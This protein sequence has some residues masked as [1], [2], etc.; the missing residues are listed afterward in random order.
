VSDNHRPDG[1]HVDRRPN[2][3]WLEDWKD[4]RPVIRLHFTVDQWTRLTGYLLGEDA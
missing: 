1:W 2:G 3:V 4:G